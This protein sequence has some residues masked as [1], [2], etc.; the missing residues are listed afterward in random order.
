MQKAEKDPQDVGAKFRDFVRLFRRY[1]SGKLSVVNKDRSS[2]RA[3]RMADLYVFSLFSPSV[4]VCVCVWV[5]ARVG[6]QS[7]L[8]SCLLNPRAQSIL[9]LP[10]VLFIDGFPVVA[11]NQS[12][13]AHGFPLAVMEMFHEAR[14][15]GWSGQGARRLLVHFGKLCACVQATGLQLKI[16]EEHLGCP[17]LDLRPACEHVRESSR[18]SRESGAS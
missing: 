10:G 9:D 11:A 8:C 13:V 14:G 4:C 18:A 17:S 5:C 2:Q 7:F 1:H 12:Y 6:C 16:K 15:Q 3:M